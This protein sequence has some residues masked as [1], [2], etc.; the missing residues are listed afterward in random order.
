MSIINPLTV[1]TDLLLCIETEFLNVKGM[2][3]V[4]GNMISHSRLKT[5]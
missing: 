3:T 4:V 1:P 2:Q 5:P